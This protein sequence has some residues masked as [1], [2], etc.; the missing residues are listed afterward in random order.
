MNKG[1]KGVAYPGSEKGFFPKGNTPDNSLPI[2]TIRTRGDGYRYIKW[3]DKKGNLNWMKVAR[4][5]WEKVHGPVPKHHKLV[6]VSGDVTNESED[7]YVL[8]TNEEMATLNRWIKLGDDEELN[9]VAITNAK[10]KQL[11][12][13]LKHEIAENRRQSVR[14]N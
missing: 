10:L 5:N 2:G 12:G 6:N 8:V 3:Q 4:W 1:M 13:R 14:G 11:I 9:R 7:N